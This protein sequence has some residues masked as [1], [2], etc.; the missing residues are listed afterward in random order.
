[1]LV[2]LYNGTVIVKLH[3]S[4]YHSPCT[5]LFFKWYLLDY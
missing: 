5:S 1:M 3:N 2:N 4:I